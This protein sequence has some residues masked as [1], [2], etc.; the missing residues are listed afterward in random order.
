MGPHHPPR[1]PSTITPS[2]HRQTSQLTSTHAADLYTVVR[3][4]GQSRI[5]SSID[6]RWICLN[7]RLAS[8]P[9]F[10]AHL[11][12]TRTPTWN[13]TL[14]CN[15]RLCGA[16]RATRRCSRS[17]VPP[18]DSDISSGKWLVPAR[19]PRPSPFQVELYADSA[20]DMWMVCDTIWPRDFFRSLRPQW[21]PGQP[22]T[23]TGC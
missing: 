7:H 4:G 6:A 15:A 18:V 9:S 5:S 12:D 16:R 8:R 21:A 14:L 1:P 2:S 20:I 17:P 23:Q 3:F 13:S 11:L 22:R 10:V 19:P